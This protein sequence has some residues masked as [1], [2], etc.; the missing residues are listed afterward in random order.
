MS[1]RTSAAQIRDPALEERVPTP[2]TDVMPGWIRHPEQ[3]GTENAAAA[4]LDPGSE[5]GVTGSVL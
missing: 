2:R 1:S 3:H 5:A 4:L